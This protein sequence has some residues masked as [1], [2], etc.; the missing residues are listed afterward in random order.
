[1]NAKIDYSKYCG[2]LF[3][4]LCMKELK[5]KDTSTI[6]VEVPAGEGHSK[7]DQAICNKCGTKAMGFSSK[8]CFETKPIGSLIRCFLLT[9]FIF[10]ILGG[11]VYISPPSEVVNRSTL[12]IAASFLTL[13]CSASIMYIQNR[14]NKICRI[15]IEK[16]ES[17]K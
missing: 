15:I 10:C 14:H 8:I 6:K 11:L 4:A 12:Y 17:N 5:E 9:L 7:V 16:I 2:S 1:M 13:F 3:C